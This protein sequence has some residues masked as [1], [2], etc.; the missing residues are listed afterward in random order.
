MRLSF[1]VALFLGFSAFAQTDT[2]TIV[3]YNLLNFPNGRNDCGSNTVVPNRADTLRKILQYVKPD[4]LVACEIQTEAGADSVLTRSLNVF[5]ANNYAAAT[6]DLQNTNAN[7]NNQLYY[8]TDKLTL[9]AQYVIQTSPR[10]IDHYVLYV[11][12]PTL[13]QF[14]D[15]TFVEV[16]MCHLKAGSGSADQATRAAQTAILRDYIATR[17]PDRNHF[18]CGDLNVYRSSEACYQNLTSGI[19]GLIDPINMPGNW[20]S[21]SSFAAIHTQSTRNGQNL[22]CGAS[23]GL[24]DRFDQILVSQGVMSGSDSLRYLPGSY[25]AIGNDGNH[26]NTN[27]LAAPLN[28]QYPDSIVR[29]LYYMSDHLPVALKAV[30][31]YPTS[32]GLALYPSATPV[33][34]PNGSNGT[35]TVTPNDGQAPFS[36]LWDAAALNQTTAAVTDLAVGYYCVEVTDALGE[37]DDVCVYVSGPAAFS[38]SVFRQPDN[39][40]C[41]GEAHV[42]F[43][44]GTA[45]YTFL[46]ND[47]EEQNGQSVFQLCAGDYE[48]TV[49]DANGCSLVIPVTILGTASLTQLD[50][51]SINVYPNPT[52]QYLTLESPLLEELKIIR[53]WSTDG[54]ACAVNLKR[55]A[56]DEIQVDLSNLNPGIYFMEVN[57]ENG[58]IVKKILKD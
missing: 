52:N 33:S 17:P 39:G 7:L 8:N 9:H 40:S 45:P 38:F 21:N 32:N 44:G 20:T 2:V 53:L 4:I 18:V 24:D 5:G 58:R 13:D 42:L 54:K 14:F 55:T 22:D 57:T 41:T 11:N 49:T 1:Y 34:C 12:D 48:V 46:W 50:P 16:Y 29:A 35:A 30:V 43:S 28:T 27:L 56:T 36:F 10:N 51:S 19:N 47:P 37:V 15:T 26:Y 31:T 23:G 25:E 3:A 6:Y